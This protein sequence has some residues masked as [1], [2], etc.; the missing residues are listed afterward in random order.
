MSLTSDKLS[1]SLSASQEN[2]SLCSKSLL[3][4]NPAHERIFSMLL[5]NT[6]KT[7]LTVNKN[8]SNFLASVLFRLSGLHNSHC[9]YF[10]ETFCCSNFSIKS[11]SFNR[12][13]LKPFFQMVFKRNWCYKRNAIRG[14][15]VALSYAKLFAK[16]STINFNDRSICSDRCG[17]GFWSAL[18]R[19]HKKRNGIII[20]VLNHIDFL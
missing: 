18:Q 16:C 15:I 9:S 6:I 1:K 20:W 10:N 5:L 8:R 3:A 11:F 4:Q 7:E 12:H 14:L 17:N 2:N 19:E 13:Q